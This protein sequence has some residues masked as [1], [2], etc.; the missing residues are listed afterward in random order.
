MSERERER[1]RERLNLLHYSEKIQ[2]SRGI[3]SI[4]SVSQLAS[5]LEL[6]SSDVLNLEIQ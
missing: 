4:F 5:E 6:K 2:R 1:E 3:I